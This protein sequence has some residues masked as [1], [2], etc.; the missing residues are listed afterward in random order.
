MA[1]TTVEIDLQISGLTG[2]TLHQFTRNTDTLVNTTGGDTLTERTNKLGWY[3]ATV[4]EAVAGFVDAIALNATNDRMGGGVC[5]MADT[6]ETYT[7]QS[8]Q[9]Q[10]IASVD[11]KTLQE[12]TR[13]IAAAVAGELDGAGTGTERVFGLDG[14]TARVKATIDGSGNRTVM[15]YDTT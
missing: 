7:V 8:D 2:L 10:A 13:Y 14:T 15:A 1:S 4:T 12:A 5:F 3:T 9:A 6:T 11:G